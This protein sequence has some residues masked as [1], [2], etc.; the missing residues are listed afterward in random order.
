MRVVV[1]GLRRREQGDGHRAGAS[2]ATKKNVL[3]DRVHV[4]R[5]APVVNGGSA[6]RD[7]CHSNARGLSRQIFSRLTRRAIDR[8]NSPSLHSART[9]TKN[10]KTSL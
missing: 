8:A 10:Q 3:V 6:R 4:D 5:V 1:S 7:P 9:K 2:N